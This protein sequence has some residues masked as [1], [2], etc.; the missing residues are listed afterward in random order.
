[1]AIEINLKKG[2]VLRKGY[3]GF[4]WTTLF[5]NFFVPLVRGDVLWFLIILGLD[6]VSAGFM[7]LIIPFF[8]NKF[9]TRS[10]I[11]K[12]GFEPADDYSRN[13]LIRAG[14]IRP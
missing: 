6:L 7:L 13:E 11:E 8:Y 5:F 14:I 10:L 2:D 9:Y 4:S 12:Q 3:L 1:M